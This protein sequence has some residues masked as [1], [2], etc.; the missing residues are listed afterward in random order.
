MKFIRTLLDHSSRI[1]HLGSQNYPR[2]LPKDFTP[3]RFED[4]FPESFDDSF[5]QSSEPPQYQAAWAPKPKRFEDS[6]EPSYDEDPLPE[7]YP[8][9]QA[10]EY[11]APVSI[12]PHGIGKVL[13][14]KGIIR[15][16]DLMEAMER[17]K[18][19]PGKYLGQILAEMGIPQSR[20]MNRIYYGN[21]RKKLGEILVELKFI[22]NQQLYDTLIEQRHLKEKGK[23]VYL[24]KL[25]V[26]NR[27]INE[28]HYITALSAHFSMPVV[29]LRNYTVMPT[30]QKAVGERYALRNRIIVL[31]DGEDD[32][33]VA[34]SEPHL[35]VFDHL[36]KA[37][38]RGKYILFHIARASEID[39]CLQMAYGYDGL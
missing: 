36:E 24:A 11:T 16:S 34:I 13:V 7:D 21:K 8:Q 20:V 10:P 38:P 18:L 23:H 35:S 1:I 14:A 22:T 31:S 25:M 19:E 9:T 26:N 5:N 3:V 27:M 2:R 33:T 6:A 32:V 39:S 29:S 30:L 17:K 15:P 37:M 28:E 4:S 12:L